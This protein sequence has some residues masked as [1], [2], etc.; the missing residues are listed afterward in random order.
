MDSLVL[1]GFRIGLLALLWLFIFFALRA[2]RRDTINASGAAQ[3]KRRGGRE[4]RESKPQESRAPANFITVAEGPL[5]GSHM[6]LAGWN[7][8]VLGRS[9]Q[10]DFVLGDDFASGRHARLFRRGSEWF[11]ED[12]D[13]RNGTFLSGL[14]IDQPERV[15]T[16][17][18]IRVGR[19]T[20]R[21]VP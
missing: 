11:I 2:M 9:E 10:C 20:V 3:T 4:A 15:A 19:T 6:E 18:D 7:D 5:R 1:M 21:L 14:R 16:G 17:A 12:L 8:I 13:S